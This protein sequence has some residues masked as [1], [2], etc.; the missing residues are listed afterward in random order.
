MPKRIQNEITLNAD[1]TLT[2]CGPLAHNLYFKYEKYLRELS[3][4]ILEGKTSNVA[5]VLE[6]DSTL[7]AG[8]NSILGAMEYM[9]ETRIL[10]KYEVSRE[11]M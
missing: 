6:V 11:P 4:V 5:Y 10:F 1:K 8:Q 2:V 9:N 7:R 3:S